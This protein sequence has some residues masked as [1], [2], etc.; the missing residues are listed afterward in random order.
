MYRIKN[1]HKKA[2]TQ[3]LVHF[4]FRQDIEICWI[5]FVSKI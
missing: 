4:Y 2:I 5:E 1:N 3:N